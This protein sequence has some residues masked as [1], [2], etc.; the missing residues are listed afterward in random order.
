[1]KLTQ[2]IVDSLLDGVHFDDAVRGL[3]IRIRGDG[4][5]YIVAWSEGD[6]MT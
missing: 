4:R 3:G 2:K 6:A 1:M 5:R